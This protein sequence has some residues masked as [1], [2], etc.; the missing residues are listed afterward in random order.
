MISLLP[1]GMEH[2]R[3]HA[4]YYYALGFIEKLLQS[5]H[6]KSAKKMVKEIMTFLKVSGLQAVAVKQ[7][8]LKKSNNQWQ[9]TDSVITI[10]ICFLQFDFSSDTDTTIEIKPVQ[11]SSVV[12]S[13]DSNIDC[14]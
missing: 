12:A 5:F 1:A 13:E 14:G 7:F 8:G 4:D 3:R 6:F 11:V 2:N 9:S 10:I